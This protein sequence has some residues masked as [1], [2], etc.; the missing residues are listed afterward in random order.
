MGVAG[1]CATLTPEL[2]KLQADVIAAASPFMLATATIEAF[3]AGHGN[4][5]WDKALIDYV[6]GFVASSSGKDFNPHVST[7]VAP[8]AYL[9]GMIAEPFRAF[10]FSIAGAAVYQLGPFGS[11]AR[12][13]KRW[14][15]S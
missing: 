9:D 10:A 1:I 3:T 7:G 4:P 12:L 15:V 13:L 2:R 8:V 5:A 14:D 6:S 11:A